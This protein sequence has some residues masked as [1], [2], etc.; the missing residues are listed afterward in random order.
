ML[1]LLAF[2]REVEIVL[3]YQ[4]EI[5]RY[6]LGL[7]IAAI[8]AV[9]VTDSSVERPEPHVEYLSIVGDDMSATVAAIQQIGE[10][11]FAPFAPLDAD[12]DIKLA[13]C[14]VPAA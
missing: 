12:P 6:Q 14:E 11:V 8:A 13:A 4:H 10:E 7:V 5:K 9:F 2:G 3:I 1:D